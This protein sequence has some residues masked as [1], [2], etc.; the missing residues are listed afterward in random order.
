MKRWILAFSL[1]LGLGWG[2]PVII[3]QVYKYTDDEGVVRYTD[4]VEQIPS[5]LKDA[6]EVQEKSVTSSEEIQSP[7]V[8]VENKKDKQVAAPEAAADTEPTLEDKARE[9][10]LAERKE[11]MTTHG[12]LTV[13]KTD[14]VAAKASVPR[15]PRGK[16]RRQHR[17]LNKQILELNSKIEAFDQSRQ[18]F[19]HKAARYQMDP[20]PELVPIPYTPRTESDSET[21]G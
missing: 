12:S 11:L 21:S 4:N 20:V 1:I 16:S 6:A 19:N 15:L 7:A 10:L 5:H 3:A 18:D 17:E 13:R 9:K 2:A 14:L 8:N